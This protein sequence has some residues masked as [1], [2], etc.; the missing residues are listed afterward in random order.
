MRYEPVHRI[1]VLALEPYEPTGI[2]NWRR[3]GLPEGHA[4]EEFLGMDRLKKV[5]I[6]LGPDPGFKTIVLS[7]TEDYRVETDYFG[8]TVRRRKDAPTMYYGYEDHPIKTADD[9]IAYK[10]EHFNPR[11]A[12]RRPENIEAVADELNACESPVGFEVFPFFFRLGFYMLGMERFMTA[13]YDDPDL[14]HEMFSFWGKFVMDAAR[15]LLSRVKLDYVCLAEDL[16]YKGGPHISPRM[17]EEFWLPYQTPIIREF[18]DLGAPTVCMWSAGDLTPLM[19]ILLEQGFNCTWPL[20]RGS[21][22]DPLALR[23]KY[24]RQ[25]L[26]AGG[27]SKEALIEGPAAITRELDCLLPLI[28]QGGYFPALDDVVPPE[29]PLSH[30]SFYVNALRSIRF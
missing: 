29:V 24:G 10:R 6:Y 4:P 11:S 1:P 7:E 13:L 26:L 3:E 25:L 21:G 16:A 14:I 20:E 27:V 2:E 17:Y 28:R 23:E 18:K 22:M 12:S 8:A 9:W 5:P 19:P 15:P 30:Y